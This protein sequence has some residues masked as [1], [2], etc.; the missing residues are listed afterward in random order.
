[1]KS[2]F[3]A[4]NVLIAYKFLGAVSGGVREVC[5]GWA[6]PSAQ[7]RSEQRSP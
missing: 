4:E 1:M 3:Q 2:S 7:H 5:E 6:K